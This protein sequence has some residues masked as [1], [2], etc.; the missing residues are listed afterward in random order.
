MRI[1][2]TSKFKN[3]FKIVHHAWKHDKALVFINLSKAV[4]DAII[5]LIGI[6]L[7]KII[8]DELMGQNR[9]SNLVSITVTAALIIFVCNLIGS[10]ADSKSWYR[11]VMLRLKLV[12][13]RGEKLMKMDFENTENP[14]V[15]DKLERSNQSISTYISAS[16]CAV[17]QIIG[18]VLAVVPNLLITIIS[19][20]IIL[21]KFSPI[22]VLFVLSTV[23]LQYIGNVKVN[24][25]QLKLNQELAPL[26]RKR[27]YYESQ[28]EDPKF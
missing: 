15:L 28:M 19:Y 13:Q 12:S 3:I 9:L 5:A 1:I 23:F 17:T 6:Y 26:Y 2:K 22:I 11:I 8:I 27:D 16:S 18:K 24:Q 4:S 25:L 21:V 10:Y 20:L 7:S 14:E